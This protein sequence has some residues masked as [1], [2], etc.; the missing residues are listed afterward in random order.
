[1][2][3][4]QAVTPKSQLVQHRLDPSEADP[5]L[6]EAEGGADAVVAE[7]VVKLPFLAGEAGEIAADGLGFA[8]SVSRS[9]RKDSAW[10]R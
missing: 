6:F 9:I 3:L 5:F 2:S 1:M 4:N 10:G 8:M 7:V